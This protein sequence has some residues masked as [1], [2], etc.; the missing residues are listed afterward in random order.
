MEVIPLAC[1][2]GLFADEDVGESDW[3]AGC[4]TVRLPWI[5]SKTEADGFIPRL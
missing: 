5:V 4:Q 1:K 2:F 3:A